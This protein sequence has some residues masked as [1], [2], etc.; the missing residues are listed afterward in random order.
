MILLFYMD[1]NNE[2]KTDFE[3]L[4]DNAK[5]LTNFP[6][7]ILAIDESAKTCCKRF[8]DVNLEC[9]TESRRA[10]REMIVTTPELGEV[11]S[12]IILT[13]ETIRQSDKNGKPFVHILMENGIKPGIKV[14]E[15]L[16]GY[17]STEDIE[18]V[19]NGLD[20]LSERMD[21]YRK[22]G[23][24]FAKWRSAFLVK[25]GLPSKEALAENID[26][27]REYVSICQAN[28][29]VPIIEPEVLMDGDHS[30]DDAQ[31]T[32]RTVLSA[33]MNDLEDSNV[34]LPGIILKTSMVVSG[35]EAKNRASAKEVE[36][37]TVETLADCVPK[38]IGG[39]IFLSG[40][41]S[42]DEANENFDAIMAISDEIKIPMTFSFSRAFQNEALEHYAKDPKDVLG[43]Q[44]ILLN[45]IKDIIKK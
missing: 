20:K 8:E 45:S 41:Q 14:D 35:K 30:I 4:S 29:I 27:M 15:G 17:R 24:V 31:K 42:H 23:A 13:D 38:E 44:K 5:Y 21:E 19:T 36:Q 12:G 40:G 26:R 32:L 6:K 11:L 16:I 39:I 22:L 7:G 18:Q 28:N 2:N 34:Y 43:S 25:E 9:N 10:F 33:L 1:N 37:K 3:L